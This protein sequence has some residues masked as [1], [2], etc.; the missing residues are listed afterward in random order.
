N[1]AMPRYVVGKLSEALD[2]RAGKAL[3]RSRVLVLGLAY[4]KNVADIRESPSLRLIEI[5]EE[6]CGHSDYHDPFVAE[7]PPT[8]EY[9]ASASPT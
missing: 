5:I 4:N 7:I 6:R 1:S 2:I 8:R 9:Q 3:S